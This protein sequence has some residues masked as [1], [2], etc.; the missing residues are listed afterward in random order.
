MPQMV[1]HFQTVR[2]DK[3]AKLDDAKLR[4]A[5]AALPEKPDDSLR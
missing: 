1:E 5:L 2:K 4:E 3:T